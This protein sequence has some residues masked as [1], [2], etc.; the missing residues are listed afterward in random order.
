M[1]NILILGCTGS[2]G[3]S[4]L[5]IAR[6]FPDRFNV[7]GLT[8][9]KSKERLQEL[10]KEFGNVPTCLTGVDS[11][12]ALERLINTCGADIVV[13]GIAGSPGLM[14]SVFVLRAGIDLALANKETIVMAG[15]LIARLA[16]EHNCRILPVDSEHSAVFTLVEKF[17][18]DSIGQIV[19][20][21]SGGPFR[22]KKSED[23]PFMR[24]ADALKHP[25]WDMGTKITIDSASLANKGLEVIEACRLFNISP[26]RVKVTVHPQSLVHSLIRTR[27]GV[28][29]AQI[30]PPDMR[31]PILTALTWPDFVPSSLEEWDITAGGTLNFYPPR[32]NDFPMLPLAYKS[33]SMAS[34]P[35]AYNAANEI[36]VEAFLNGK[37]AFT[38]I[39]YVTDRILAMDWN[40]EPVTIDDVFL[41]DNKARQQAKK[42][43]EDILCGII[44]QSKTCLANRSWEVLG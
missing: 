18:S 17:G 44:P 4:A 13:N 36:A 7:V 21:A 9:H 26:D 8:A 23:L 37:I 24:P 27:D 3:T 25:T 39:A 35:I 32:M 2:I 29:Y 28:L 6:E 10:S 41:F 38:Q 12:D 16:R 43:V 31:H 19:L 22:E 1:K 42:I 20:T 11:E 34:G 33:L 40:K 15:P 5:N 30:S 14:P